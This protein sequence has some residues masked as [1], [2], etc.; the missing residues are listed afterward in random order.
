M[1]NTSAA[2]S[3]G[4]GTAAT[5]SH[6][7]SLWVEL[8]FLQ[9]RNPASCFL[10]S[11]HFGFEEVHMHAWAESGPPWPLCLITLCNFFKNLIWPSSPLCSNSPPT[12]GEVS[13]TEAPWNRKHSLAF[14]SLTGKARH[15]GLPSIHPAM[16]QHFISLLAGKQVILQSRTPQKG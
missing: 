8:P 5:G 3:W 13:V 10:Y 4:K 1:P 14:K 6:T 2:P 15:G 9:D 11:S 7:L 12:T 16:K